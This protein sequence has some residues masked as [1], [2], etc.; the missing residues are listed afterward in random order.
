MQAA[1]PPSQLKDLNTTASIA[2]GSESSRVDDLRSAV[3][4]DLQLSLAQQ[5]QN[6]TLPWP[7]TCRAPLIDRTR[8]VHLPPFHRAAPRTLGPVGF[9]DRTAFRAASRFHHCVFWLSAAAR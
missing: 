4:E 1:Y 5:P 2:K 8:L 3:H 9:A 6:Q 7:K